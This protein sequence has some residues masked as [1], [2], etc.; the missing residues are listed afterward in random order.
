MPADPT[1]TVVRMDGIT[2]HFGDLVANDDV[3]LAIHAGRVHAVVGEN[4]AGK[5]TLMQILCGALRADAGTVALRG[6]HVDFRSTSDAIAAGVGMVYQHFKLVMSMTVGDNVVLGDEPTAR[7]GL[8]DREAA[9]REVEELSQRYALDVP[10]DLPVRRAS[11]GVRQKVEILRVLRRRPDVVVLDEPTAVLSPQEIEDLLGFVRTLAEQGTAVV[12]ITHKLREVFAVADDIT[13]LRKGRVVG[14]PD[15]SEVTPEELATM[16]VGRSVDTNLEREPVA[17]H[18]EPLWQASGLT[19]ID[20][21]GVRRLDAI[22]LRIH[23]GEILG[24]AGV[25]G[26]GQRELV[27]VLT[28]A[29]IAYE[30]EITWRGQVLSDRG[31]RSAIRRGVSHV[32]EDRQGV[33]MIPQW[34]LVDNSV[35]RRFTSPR[36][37]SV[38]RLRRSAM[39]AQAMRILTDFDIAASPEAAGASLSGGNQQRLIVGRELVAEPAL[40]VAEQPTRGV[41]VGA[42]S[43]IYDQLLTIRGAGAAAVVVSFDLDELLALADRIVVL[44]TGRI[45]ADLTRDQANPA[46]IGKLMTGAVEGVA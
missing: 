31:V 30:G 16:M 24:V 46:L 45:V 37:G 18:A 17:R 44:Y 32:P 2:K 21:D 35:L 10:Q 15:P 5:S 26:N 9:R 25:D 27:D 36:F 28:G 23:A 40:V 8:I 6:Q 22:D 3:D 43:F 13:V 34:P 1:T 39:R 11:V 29:T 38:W 4:G 19:V 12:L 41:D 20:A 14:D 7:T 42:S 33:G